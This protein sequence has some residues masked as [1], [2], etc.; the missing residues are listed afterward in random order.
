MVKLEDL[1][2]YILNPLCYCTDLNFYPI[3]LV[4]GYEDV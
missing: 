3:F 4:K 1:I 2:V